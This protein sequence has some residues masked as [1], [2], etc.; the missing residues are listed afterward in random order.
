MSSQPNEPGNSPQGPVLD[1]SLALIRFLRQNCPW[2]AAQTPESLV[3]Y[4]LEEAHEVADAIV[5]REARIADRGSGNQLASEL[6][7]LLLNVAFQIVLAEERG[8]FTA[9][10]VIQ[11]LEQKMRR[12]HPQLYGG[13]K[14]DWE[15]LKAVE[16]A[17][18]GNSVLHGLARS[19]DPLS[20][21][22]G[23]A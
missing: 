12:R 20:K 22:I 11:A 7:D 21:E 3:P 13:E 4:L 23:R 14:A 10:T 18:S 2:D 16:R 15:S 17:E 9:E 6:G 19:L 8:D 5:D 1:R